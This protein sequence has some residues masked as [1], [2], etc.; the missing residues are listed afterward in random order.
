MAVNIHDAKT[1]FSQLLQRVAEGEEIIIAKSGRP[2]ARLIPIIDSPPARRP[3]SARGQVKLRG[4][5][6][7]PLPKR[8]QRHF[9]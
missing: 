2:I 1:H 9:Q 8:V 4:N 7:A 6:D 3:G 5:F